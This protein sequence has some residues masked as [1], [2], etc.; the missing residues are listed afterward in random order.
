[1]MC[2]CFH[3]ILPCIQDEVINSFE[4]RYAECRAEAAQHK[5]ALATSQAK[6]ENS[7]LRV[8]ELVQSKG[9]LRRQLDQAAATGADE[10]AALRAEV[11][12]LQVGWVL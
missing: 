3:L 5:E 4:A 6:L 11:A 12:R 7:Q 2:L 9:E 1:M 10:G 8:S